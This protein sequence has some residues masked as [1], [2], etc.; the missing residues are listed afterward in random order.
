VSTLE[1]QRI[2]DELEGFLRKRFRITER[3]PNKFNHRVNLWDA[4]Y[5]DSLG[6]VEVITHLEETYGI[7]IPD[8][9]LFSESITT[10]EGLAALAHATIHGKSGS[11]HA[12]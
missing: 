9:A 3:D 12:A 10:I 2:A 11:G 6:T 8:N 4:G 1:V 5:V 7:K